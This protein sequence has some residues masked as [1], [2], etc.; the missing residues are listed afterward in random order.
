MY[1]KTAMTSAPAPADAV[2][3]FVRT[4]RGQFFPTGNSGSAYAQFDN[5]SDANSA[6]TLICK[7]GGWS[8]EFDP[9]YKHALRIWQS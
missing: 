7:L 9:N 4:F 3:E 2:R 5:F 8:A 1:M 6:C